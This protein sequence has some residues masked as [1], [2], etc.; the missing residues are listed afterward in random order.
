MED[1]FEDGTDGDVAC[2]GR[3]DEGKTRRREAQVGGVG[4]CPLCFVESG[5][6]RRRPGERLGFSGEGSVERSHGS[7]NVRQELMIVVNRADELLQGLHGGGCQN[8]MNSCNVMAQEV[9]FLSPKDAFVMEEDETSRAETFKDWVQVAPALFSGR[10]ES[11]DV[12]GVGKAEGEIAEDDVYH[13]L[14][15]G[16]SVTKAKTG[17]I[18]SVGA[19]GRGDGGFWDVVWMHGFLVVA[20]YE[21]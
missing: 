17:V 4:E 19:E 1:L 21:V 5:S 11:E 18:E 9:D 14:K 15:G 12:I 20:F 3:Q 7:S 13:L 6:M 2:V 10:G 8:G 16:T